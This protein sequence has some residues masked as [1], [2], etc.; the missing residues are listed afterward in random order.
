V[1]TSRRTKGKRRLVDRIVGAVF[2]VIGDL[3]LYWHDWQDWHT[4]T[5]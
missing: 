3:F 2:T 5:A 1:S 4:F